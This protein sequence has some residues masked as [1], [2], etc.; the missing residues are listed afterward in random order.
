[1]NIREKIAAFARRQKA[2]RDLKA[3][4]ARQLA[5]IGLTRAD[6]FAMERGHLGH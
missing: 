5:D 1:M 3:L 2:I 6:I 4:D